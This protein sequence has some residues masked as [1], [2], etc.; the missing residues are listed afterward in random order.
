MLLLTDLQVRVSAHQSQ[1]HDLRKENFV[2]QGAFRAAQLCKADQGAVKSQRGK[3]DLVCKLL[4]S[5]GIIEEGDSGGLRVREHKEERQP[6]VVQQFPDENGNNA[7]VYLEECLARVEEDI[8][9][10]EKASRA[11]IEEARRAVSTASDLYVQA[12]K[13]C[14]QV[15]KECHDRLGESLEESGERIETNSTRIFHLAAE[16]E[17]LTKAMKEGGAVAKPPGIVREET[18]VVFSA[19]IADL[20]QQQT[21]ATMS[22]PPKSPVERSRP[23]RLQKRSAVKRREED[24]DDE[25]AQTQDDASRSGEDRSA[26]PGVLGE[27]CPDNH[28][29]P[30]GSVRAA[31]LANSLKQAT[32]PPAQRRR[33]ST[34]VGRRVVLSRSKEGTAARGVVVG[35]MRPQEDP[36]ADEQETAP[37]SWGRASSWPLLGNEASVAAR[38]WHDLRGSDQVNTD[39]ETGGKRSDNSVRGDTPNRERVLRGSDGPETAKPT[40]AGLGDVEAM[41]SSPPLRMLDPAIGDQTDE[42]LARPRRQD[43]DT[44]QSPKKS[45]KSQQSGDLSEYHQ[46]V[47][48]STNRPDHRQPPPSPRALTRMTANEAAEALQGV[49]TPSLGRPV[50]TT[51]E[52]QH[53]SATSTAAAVVGLD[54]NTGVPGAR[55]ACLVDTPDLWCPRDTWDDAGADELSSSEGSSTVVVAVAEERSHESRDAHASPPE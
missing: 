13:K 4:V 53:G 45:E 7:V 50:H 32:S 43:D 30:G 9:R 15:Q 8:A 21:T 47:D 19:E 42:S 5:A 34:Y 31:F 55:L 18:G 22:P 41:P 36:S 10:I 6:D 23:A 37:S 26:R 46:A 39:A 33:H 12:D 25:P 29:H 49:A 2:T 35:P 48:N 11:A 14:R 44:P 28:G 52:E 3:L 54:T 40:P 24:D 16:V 20:P 1:T 17:G 27:P 38:R 51:E